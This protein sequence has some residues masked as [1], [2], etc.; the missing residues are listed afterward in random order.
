MM[1]LYE[2]E[3]IKNKI[4]EAQAVVVISDDFSKLLNHRREEIIEILPCRYF[5][6][7]T[8]FSETIFDLHLFI[9]KEHYLKDENYNQFKLLKLDYMIEYFKKLDDYFNF[10]KRIDLNPL[11]DLSEKL[12]ELNK[13]M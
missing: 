4:D 1:P 7:K 10:C 9:F 3:E 11:E 13:E 12:Y 5:K 8:V 6:I 2:I